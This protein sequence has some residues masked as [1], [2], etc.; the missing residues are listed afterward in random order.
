MEQVLAFAQALAQSK[1]QSL[2]Q[3]LIN[4]TFLP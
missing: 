1:V 2:E 4:F 3:F